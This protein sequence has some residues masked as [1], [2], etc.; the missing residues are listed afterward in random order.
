MSWQYFNSTS[1]SRLVE[2]HNARVIEGYRSCYTMDNQGAPKMMLMN[3]DM[4]AK[5][6]DCPYPPTQGA[7]VY[8]GQACYSGV[9]AFNTALNRGQK[10]DDPDFP[11][12]RCPDNLTINNDNL[13]GAAGDD[14]PSTDMSW[15]FPNNVNVDLNT[16][17]IDCNNITVQYMPNDTFSS[18]FP[19][20]QVQ[21]PSLI[22]NVPGQP[23]VTPT[24]PMYY[25]TKSQCEAECTLPQFPNKS[26]QAVKNSLN[27][28]LAQGALNQRPF[29]SAL[30]L[31]SSSATSAD[32]NSAQRGG[33]T[34]MVD[35]D[36]SCLAKGD[37]NLYTYRVLPAS[38]DVTC[39]QLFNIL[40]PAPFPL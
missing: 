5:A 27:E 22:Q 38:S 32:S 21:R 39:S 11:I 40:P 29:C 13:Y 20:L 9:N 31:C 33:N 37:D 2:N 18:C 1:Y 7:S 15:V 10:L 3:D 19:I 30:P 12:P 24:T 6:I 26:A 23:P 14:D 36:F 25:S 17:L 8:P 35:A 28:A 4:T 34:A 16:N